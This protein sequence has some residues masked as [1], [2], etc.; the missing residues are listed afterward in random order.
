MIKL[1]YHGHSFFELQDDKGQSILIDPFLEGNPH[2]QKQPTDFK[3]NAIIVT[4]AHGDHFGQ[5]DII[6]KNN[7]TCQFI[8]TFELVNW[9]Q[10]HKGL[11]YTHPM[12]IGGRHSFDFG[13]VK[14]TQA[15]HGSS[16][17][18]VTI[19]V[20]T[21]VIV[22]MGGVTVYH[23]GDTGLFGDMKL[24]GDREQIDIAILPIGDNFTM[25]VEDALYA[26]ELIRP[27]IAIP[28]HYKTFPVIEKEPE[29]FIT[30]LPDYVEGVVLGFG[31]TKEFI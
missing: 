4:H 6:C 27:K 14:F 7:P 17:G 22:Q 9:V 23:A 26:T 12:H 19:G 30:K 24:I 16:D 21:G 10:A 8:S 13:T 29:A 25:G 18:E 11:E 2:T 3:P 1:T 20:A 5:S 15:L 28:M 31:E